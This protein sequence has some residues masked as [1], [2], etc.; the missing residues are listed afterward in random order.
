[1]ADCFRRKGKASNHSQDQF[2]DLLQT[3]FSPPTPVW[4]ACETLSD[5]TRTGNVSEGGRGEGERK[6]RLTDDPERK[7]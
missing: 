3:N 6:T 2:V 1:M 4:K 5:E 7:G